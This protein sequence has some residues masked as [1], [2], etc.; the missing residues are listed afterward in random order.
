MVTDPEQQNS[1]TV[2]IPHAL[3][4][5]AVDRACPLIIGGQIVKYAAFVVGDSPGALVRE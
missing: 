3:F 5:Q 1:H 2:F 4:G